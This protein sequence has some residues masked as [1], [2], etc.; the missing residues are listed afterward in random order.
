MCSSAR[1]NTVLLEDTLV[2]NMTPS[3]VI[4]EGNFDYT[5]LYQEVHLVTN[6]RNLTTA[7]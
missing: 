2:S 7:F 1:G 5:Q 6:D 3:R 4:F